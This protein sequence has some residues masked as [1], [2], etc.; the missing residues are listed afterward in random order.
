MA[1]DHC[2]KARADPLDWAT[3]RTCGLQ[4]QPFVWRRNFQYLQPSSIQR[5]MCLLLY[6]LG[7]WNVT[8]SPGLWGEWTLNQPK[9]LWVKQALIHGLCDLCLVHTRLT[10]APKGS[11][12]SLLH[13]KQWFLFIPQSVATSPQLSELVWVPQPGLTLTLYWSRPVVTIALVLLATGSSWWTT[14][15]PLPIN[16]ACPASLLAFLMTSSQAPLFFLSLSCLRRKEK[17]KKGKLL[18]VLSSGSFPSS[19]D[20]SYLSHIHILGYQILTI[21]NLYHQSRFPPELE[22]QFQKGLSENETLK[23]NLL[24]TLNILLQSINLTMILLPPSAR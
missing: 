24:L 4:C 3:Q 7:C 2:L 11:S 9:L 15:W 12:L 1:A 13:E 23:Q 8:W 21:Y 19:Q 16:P 17:G 22:T 6:F 18:Q 20:P 10:L 5:V 14:W